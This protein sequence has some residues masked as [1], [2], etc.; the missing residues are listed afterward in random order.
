[1]D[2][3]KINYSKSNGL[4]SKI[5]SNNP[6]I[7]QTSQNRRGMMDESYKNPKTEFTLQQ[8]R[9]LESKLEKERNERE[10]AE[11]NLKILNYEFSRV[12]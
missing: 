7:S 3:S 6:N 5:D 2:V 12:L 11:E 4:I 10:D 1:M 9:F 8:K